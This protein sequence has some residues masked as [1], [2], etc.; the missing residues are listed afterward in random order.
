[1]GVQEIIDQ[2]IEA[3]N[4]KHDGEM[5]EMQEELETCN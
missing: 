2:I 3:F 1:M 5:L 4:E